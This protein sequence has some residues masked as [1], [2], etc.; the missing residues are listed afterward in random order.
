MAA[1]KRRRKG[2]FTDNEPVEGPDGTKYYPD[3]GR[4]TA[5]GRLLYYHPESA[6]QCNAEGVPLSIAATLADYEDEN[7]LVPAQKG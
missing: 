5:D 6:I 3:G 2:L 4:Q 7:G 1:S